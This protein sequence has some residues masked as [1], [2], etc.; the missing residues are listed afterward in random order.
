MLIRLL[1][2]AVVGAAVALPVTV[3]GNIST[4]PKGE[5]PPEVHL[6]ELEM[7][8][9]EVIPE[10]K[11]NQ[12]G[13]TVDWSVT[14]LNA[15]K[16]WGRGLTGKGVTFCV[17]DTGIDADH[18]DVKDNLIE[19]KDFT[20]SRTGTVDVVGHGTHCWGSIAATKNGW[21]L[22]GVAYEAKG[23]A[24]K[25]L[26]DSGSG[27]TDRIAAG[28][29]WAKEKKVKV[30]SMS[31]G[32]GG[33]DPYLP[34]AL[35]ELEA[36]G[37]IVVAAN[38]NDSGG[39]VSYPAAYKQCVAISAVDKAKRLASFSNVGR[40]TEAAGP[41]VAVRSTYP[42][43][44]FADLSG[45]S[46]ATPNVA[47]VACLW[48][49]WADEEGLPMAGRPDKFRKFLEGGCEDLGIPGR[50]ADFGWGLPDCGKIPTKGAPKP[51]E[52][53]PGKGGVTFD[54]S[55]LNEKGLKKLKDAGLDGFL[56]RLG[57]AQSADPVAPKITS[58]ELTKR[59]VAG[60]ELV[61]AIG[62]KLDLVK[63][64]NGFELVETAEQAGVEPG[65]YKCTKVIRVR[66]D[67]VE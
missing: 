9:T 54:E 29:R 57:K 51:P 27:S 32:G 35:A 58:E 48:S 43:N 5:K 53:P 6:D 30:C 49:Q 17:L 60:E 28:L 16:A 56:F 31:L 37:I 15:E 61:V 46:M 13:D 25:V 59:V 66:L 47:G 12:T 45:T 22:Q 67:K 55:D 39:P 34:D 10:H 8:P 3:P 33:T 40:K 63:W 20:G 23:F 24:A 19:A 44:R 11:A 62:V 36:A 65:T 2:L 18:R 4:D 38:G 21:G 26:G 64:P 7:R 14:V 50:D 41:G 52:P 1:Q 42:G